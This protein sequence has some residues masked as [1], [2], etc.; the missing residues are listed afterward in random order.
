M[1]SKEFAPCKCEDL[2]LLYSVLVEEAQ[3]AAWSAGVRSQLLWFKAAPKAGLI[4]FGAFP[5]AVL[6]I[7]QT[8]HET[9]KPF[10][11]AKVN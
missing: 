9:Q 3:G 4:Y 5:T 2:R 7:L 10:A 1:Q 8:G 11:Q 6:N